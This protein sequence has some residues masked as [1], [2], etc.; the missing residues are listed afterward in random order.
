MP[1]NITNDDENF[2]ITNDLNGDLLSIS[3][4]NLNAPDQA[5]TSDRFDNMQFQ[6]ILVSQ[7]DYE[8]LQVDWTDYHAVIHALR[9]LPLAKIKLESDR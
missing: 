9:L 6:V 1:F 2:A 7:E 8:S 4:Q 3:I 5:I